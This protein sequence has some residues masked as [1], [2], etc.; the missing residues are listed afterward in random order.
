MDGATRTGPLSHQSRNG[1]QPYRLGMVDNATSQ[2][3]SLK[4]RNGAQPYRLGMA[5]AVKQAAAEL[6]SRNGAQPYR[7]GM[8][9]WCGP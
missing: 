8:A 9:L 2:F 4:C 6:D 5:A 7:L 1:A 3:K